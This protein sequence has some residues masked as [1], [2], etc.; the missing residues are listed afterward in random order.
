M[1]ESTRQ[2]CE[3]YYEAELKG[4]KEEGYVKFNL[5]LEEI[6]DVLEDIS[7]A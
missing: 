6:L 4:N 3:D 5:Q 7:R 1:R 2:G